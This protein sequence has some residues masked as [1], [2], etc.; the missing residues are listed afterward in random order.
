MNETLDRPSLAAQAPVTD[1]STQ[2]NRAS[3]ASVDAER[4][5]AERRCEMIAV[6]AYY[7]SLH[8]GSQAGFELE[9]WLDAEKEIDQRLAA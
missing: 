6:A 8:R 2:D 5:A 3:A 7:R 9:D 1:E 4:A